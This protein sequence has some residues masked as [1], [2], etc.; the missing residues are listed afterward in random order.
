[1][2]E[3]RPTPTR[4]DRR[5]VG[6]P[7]EIG[8]RTVQPVARVRGR[9]GAGSGPSG[10]AAGGM[11]RVEP[12]EVL[13]READGAESALALPNPTAQAVRGMAGVAAAVAVVSVAVNIVVRLARRF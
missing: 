4:I 3:T 11:L 2:P 1:M 8:D 7:I 10:G 6:D 12:V 13:V 5:V 9:V